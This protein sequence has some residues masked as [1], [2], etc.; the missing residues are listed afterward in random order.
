MQNNISTTDNVH[1]QLSLAA[2]ENWRLGILNLYIQ[3]PDAVDPALLYCAME[4]VAPFGVMQHWTDSSL[5]PFSEFY[6][7]SMEFI[8]KVTHRLD[9]AWL[10][11]ESSEYPT[12]YELEDEFGKGRRVELIRTIE[13]CKV[14]C[15]FDNNIYEALTADAGAPTEANHLS[16]SFSVED[17]FQ[18]YQYY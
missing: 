10:N 18:M 15:L 4:R 5:D 12:F 3:K 9:Q 7:V 1:K 8:D 14:R 11:N 13:L 17:R 6:S 16:K 2:Y